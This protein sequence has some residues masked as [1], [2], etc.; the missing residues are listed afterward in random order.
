MLDEKQASYTALETHGLHQTRRQEWGQKMIANIWFCIEEFEF[1]ELM[2]LQMLS[3][4]QYL[5][6]AP[7]IDPYQ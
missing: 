3:S 4:L 1:Y 5:S 2:L 7:C 6:P